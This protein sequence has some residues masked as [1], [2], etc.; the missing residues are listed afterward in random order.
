MFFTG[1]DLLLENLKF[2]EN[3]AIN[4][5]HGL[6]IVS[7]YSSSVKIKNCLFHKGKTNKNPGN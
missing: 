2:I 4:P 6:G 7:D 5:V 1:G 3:E